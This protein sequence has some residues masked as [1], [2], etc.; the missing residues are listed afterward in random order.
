MCVQVYKN[1]FYAVLL[2]AMSTSLCLFQCMF[3][4][5]RVC[6]VLLCNKMNNNL[7]NINIISDTVFVFESFQ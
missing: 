4:A 6:I 7:L 3:T 5:V 2:S 1:Y